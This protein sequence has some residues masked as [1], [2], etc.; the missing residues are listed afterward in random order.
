M[1]DNRACTSGRP[2]PMIDGLVE[3]FAEEPAMPA[4]TASRLGQGRETG[5]R[6]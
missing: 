6:V 3:G 5:G 4:P 1:Y 2:E